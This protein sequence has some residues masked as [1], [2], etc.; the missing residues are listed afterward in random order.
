MGSVPQ[1]SR[2]T[3]KDWGIC[4]GRRLDRSKW[5]VLCTWGRSVC[6][7]KGVNL[8]GVIVVGT[9]SLLL[10]L[11]SSLSAELSSWLQTCDIDTAL[12]E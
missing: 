11:L 9:S 6:V 8:Q 2:Q 10:R 1:F 7:E 4:M 3:E 5:G 12:R